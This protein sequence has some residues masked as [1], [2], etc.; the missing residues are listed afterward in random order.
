[1]A[2]L[3]KIICKLKYYSN[4]V[5]SYGLADYCSQI[6]VGYEIHGT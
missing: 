3:C 5:L 2:N 6:F 4:N 1:M